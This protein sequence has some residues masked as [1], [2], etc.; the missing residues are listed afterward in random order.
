MSC[1]SVH[2]AKHARCKDLW[3]GRSWI[4]CD[5]PCA[6]CL[7]CK[8]N[9]V[10]EFWI[11]NLEEGLYMALVILVWPLIHTAHL[12]RQLGVGNHGRLWKQKAL[13][14]LLLNFPNTLDT[15]LSGWHPPISCIKLLQEV[16]ML[17]TFCKILVSRNCFEV[18]ASGQGLSTKVK[19]HLLWELVATRLSGKLAFS[20]CT[21]RGG[22]VAGVRLLC[23]ITLLARC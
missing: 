17:S 14:A 21:E 15:A 3:T 18:E 13:L 20:S 6:L 8:R 10:F 23:G 16:L 5:L 7:I 12:L 11:P 19:V 1:A 2:P 22:F 4:S 9:E